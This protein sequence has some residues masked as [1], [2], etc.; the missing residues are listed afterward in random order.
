[1]FQ[2]KIKNER[3]LLLLLKNGDESAFGLFFKTYYKDLVL[4]AGKFISSRV[5]C[6]DITQSVFL[7]LWDE[8]ETL[9]IESSLKSF[10]LKSV[11][12]RCLNVLRHQLYEEN[13]LN[14][15]KQHESM[16]VPTPEHYLLYSE[17]HTH[18]SQALSRLPYN[19]REAFEL[20]RFKG[21]TYQEIA[22]MLNVSKRTIEVRIGQALKQL[23]ID[24]KE[25]FLILFFL[26]DSMAILF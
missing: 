11:Q 24:L 17:I 14:S 20:N 2:K 21:L 16:T 7:Q 9:I 23:R 13:Y 22:D 6:E 8:R 26:I 18:L 12:N 1:M 3:E 25:I 15:V 4:F 19:Q 5:I 10:L